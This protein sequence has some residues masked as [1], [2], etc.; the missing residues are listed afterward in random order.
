MCAFR[1]S[2]QA[3][4]GFLRLEGV[5]DF[6]HIRQ[7]LPRLAQRAPGDLGRHAGEVLLGVEVVSLGA[8]DGRLPPQG[9]QRVVLDWLQAPAGVRV[10]RTPAGVVPRAD[11]ESPRPR[12]PR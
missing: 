6:P 11:R 2:L 3:G 8:G 12:P 9:A 4:L 10:G 1:D 7:E 5:L